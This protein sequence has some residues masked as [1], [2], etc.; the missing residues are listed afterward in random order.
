MLAKHFLWLK[1]STDCATLPRL[2]NKNKR[3]LGVLGRI[4]SAL[5]FHWAEKF[6]FNLLPEKFAGSIFVSCKCCHPHGFHLL[7]TALAFYFCLFYFLPSDVWSQTLE[8]I[9]VAND[10][11]KRVCH[12]LAAP[13][14]RVS[15][16]SNNSLQLYPWWVQAKCLYDGTMPFFAVWYILLVVIFSQRVVSEGQLC[17]CL[18]VPGVCTRLC[19][20]FE[21]FLY[22]V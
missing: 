13:S 16:D 22:L 10:F 3:E 11:S 19:K 15:Q 12:S 5:L 2:R 20:L 9:N 17:A 7:L 18:S 4:N 8:C 1:I 14:T 21:A 6:C